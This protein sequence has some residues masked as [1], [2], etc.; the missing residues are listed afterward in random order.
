MTTG[1]VSAVRY[2]PL[3]LRWEIQSDAAINPGN[4]GGPMVLAS[5]EMVGINTFKR[6]FS[7][8]GRQVE[9]VG[10]AISEVTIRERLGALKTGQY[11]TAPTPTPLPIPRPTATAVPQPTPGLIPGWAC[12]RISTA[13]PT[14]NAKATPA[15]S[16][17]APLDYSSDGSWRLWYYDPTT[18]ELTFFDSR[19]AF[20]SA[21]TLYELIDGQIYCLKV[22]NDQTVALNGKERRLIAGDNTLPW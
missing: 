19:P 1:I 8:D 3:S 5:G 16:A 14:P 6:F 9:G 7:A 20:A 22:R 2:E 12:D 17:L 13:P 15:R 11:R 21:N 18:E 10:F 4:S